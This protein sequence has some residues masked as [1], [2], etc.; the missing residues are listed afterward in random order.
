LPRD[1]NSTS[2]KRM[3]STPPASPPRGDQEETLDLTV[4][5]PPPPSSSLAAAPGRGGRSPVGAG[6]GEASSS[7]CPGKWTRGN[8]SRPGRGACVGCHS[9][10][11]RRLVLPRRRD[12]RRGGGGAASCWSATVVPGG[13]MW[14]AQAT[15][16]R[17]CSGWWRWRRG[18]ARC[19]PSGPGG[20][21]STGGGSTVTSRQHGEALLMDRRC[22]WMH[23]GGAP[24]AAVG[25]SCSRVWLQACT[26]ESE[27][28][29]G[30]APR[31]C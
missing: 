27:G 18:G 1:R 11:A 8:F 16:G 13:G 22:Q 3:D 14:A 21:R 30:W 20:P 10:M 17:L 15:V 6:S 24:A 25:S 23:G 31:W 2:H 9:V 29:D 28:A 26:V 19:G 5:S 12:R 4:G 7:S